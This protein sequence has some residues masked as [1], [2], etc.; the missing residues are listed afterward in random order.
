[1]SVDQLD[2]ATWCIGNL[3]SRLGVSQRDLFNRPDGSGIRFGYIVPAYDSLH[4][5]GKTS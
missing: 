2:F 4:T 5:L 3:S 1:M